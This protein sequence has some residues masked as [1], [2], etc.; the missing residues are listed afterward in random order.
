MGESLD[1]SDR[2][3]AAAGVRGRFL[4]PGQSGTKS[5]KAP[6]STGSSPAGHQS[7]ELLSRQRA[8]LIP[9]LN[10]TQPLTSLPSKPWSAQV[11]AMVTAKWS[12]VVF[13]FA[14]PQDAEAL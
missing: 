11:V 13:Y 12:V 9:P 10:R 1:Q 8:D 5:P 14:A 6:H 4:N 3:S 2:G 7:L